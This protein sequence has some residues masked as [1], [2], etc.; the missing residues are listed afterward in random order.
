MDECK[1]PKESS[2]ANLSQN[3]TVMS[4]SPVLGSGQSVK[5]FRK[6]TK[7]PCKTAKQKLEI[8]FQTQNDSLGTVEGEGDSVLGLSLSR[9]DNQ[10]ESVQDRIRQLEALQNQ[11]IEI[12]RELSFQ[13]PKIDI[14]NE[15]EHTTTQQPVAVNQVSKL[16]QPELLKKTHPEGFFTTGLGK[17]INLSLQQEQKSWQLFEDIL[18]PDKKLKPPEKQLNYLRP[19]TQ[20]PATDNK[21]VKQVVNIFENENFG[22]LNMKANFQSFKSAKALVVPVSSK[23]QEKPQKINRNLFESENFDDLILNTDFQSFKSAR[24]VQN[25]DLNNSKPLKIVKNIFENESF[26]DLGD[27]KSCRFQPAS[28]MGIT[29]QVSSNFKPASD[30]F[31]SGND[32]FKGEN[33]HDLRTV[34]YLANTGFRTPKRQFGSRKLPGEL[35]IFT[36]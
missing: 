27:F 11:R 6:G 28:F 29:E 8:E 18:N 25:S 4:L 13:N 15:K 31:H 34:D 21:T 1:S 2:V 36:L 9:L 20:K 33:F 3:D 22:D 12:V 5:R 16:R 19:N 17:P 30:Q 26:E 32:V 10:P 35:K 23:D 7:K 14:L 24:A